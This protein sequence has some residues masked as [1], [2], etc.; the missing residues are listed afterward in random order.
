MGLFICPVIHE[1]SLLNYIEK[2]KRPRR[3]ILIELEVKHKIQGFLESQF[4]DW[5]NSEDIVVNLMFVLQE[6]GFM[7]KLSSSE[8]FDLNTLSQ[9][10]LLP[11]LRQF[12]NFRWNYDL[13][14]EV[15]TLGRRIFQSNQTP[16]LAQW[17]CNLQVG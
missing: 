5:A 15:I 10:Y 13:K 12:G 1:L 6:I 2:L 14:I 11:S 7:I 4:S 9:S 17:F 3:A 8:S 16:F